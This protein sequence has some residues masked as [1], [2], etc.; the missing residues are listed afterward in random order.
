MPRA[1]GRP[2]AKIVFHFFEKILCRGLWPAHRRQRWFFIF[3]KKLSLP[4]A[5]GNY[6]RQSWEHPSWENLFPEL[7]RV[8]ARSTRQRALCWRPLSAKRSLLSFIFN[9]LLSALTNTHTHIYDDI[10]CSTHTTHIYHIRTAAP[11][12]TSPQVHHP[13][14]HKCLKSIETSSQHDQQRQR[15][16]GDCWCSGKGVGMDPKHPNYVIDWYF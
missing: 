11:I 3:S 16:Y 12:H 13:Q 5:P 9:F 15:D 1:C 14:I 6:G 7:P 4:S 2:S 10:T 8:I